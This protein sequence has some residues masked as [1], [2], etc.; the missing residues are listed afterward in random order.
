MLLIRWVYACPSHV[1]FLDTI[2]IVLLSQL[3][4][5]MTERARAKGPELDINAWMS[6]VSLEI[7]GVALLAHPF[8]CFVDG[9][10]DSLGESIRLFLYASIF[11]RNTSSMLI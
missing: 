5:A 6:D 10:G 7:K 11:S 2:V 8:G 3:R 9:G 4:D 1:T